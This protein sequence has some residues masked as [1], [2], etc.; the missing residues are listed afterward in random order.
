[1]VGSFESRCW[2]ILTPVYKHF[3]INKTLASQVATEVNT[4]AKGCVST[5]DL[6]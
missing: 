3:N 2:A 1:M 6:Q 5:N 4:K